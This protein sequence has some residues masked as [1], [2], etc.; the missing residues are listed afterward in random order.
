M[1]NNNFQ[2]KYSSVPSPQEIQQIGKI[3]RQC[4]GISLSD[5]EFFLDRLGSASFRILLQEEKIIAS[6]A[7]YFMGQWF[8]G[9][10]VPMAGISLVSVAPEARG[11]GA[12]RE[13]LTHI[14]SE[15]YS[16]EIPISALYPATVALYRQV[17]YEQS[18]SY[19]RWEL[20]T[21]S[22][23]LKEHH[24]PIKQISLSDRRIFEPI[25]HQQAEVNN[26]NLARHFAIWSRILKPKQEEDIY[27]YLLGSENEPEGYIIFTQ[28]LDKQETAIEIRDS[29]LLTPAAAKSLWTFLANHRSLIKNVVWK[30]SSFNPFTLLLPEQTAKMVKQ[31][32]WMLRIINVP[33]ALSKRGYPQELEA[34]LHLDIQDELIAANNGKFCLKVS[35]GKGEVSIGGKGDFQIDIRSL[36][37]I[38]TSFVSPQQQQQLGNLKTTPEALATANLIFSGDCPWMADFF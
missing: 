24:L 30:G 2:Y 25:Y 35:Q 20:P 34:E 23:Q 6:L 7:V 21:N 19:C 36:A 38:Y 16:L 37:S 10:M 18:G 32:N 5:W 11:K 27:A 29:V 26:G 14:I 12:A 13:I 15:L 1:G 3:T 28:N 9:R 31:L 33:L 22:I 4:F 17:G 8:N